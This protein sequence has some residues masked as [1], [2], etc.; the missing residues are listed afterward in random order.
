MYARISALATA[1]VSG[2]LTIQDALHSTVNSSIQVS[3]TVQPAVTPVLNVSTASLTLPTTVQG[4]AGAT[5]SFTANGSGLGSG[6]TLTLVAPTGSEISKDGSSFFNSI[7]LYPDASGNLS[8][9]TVYTRISASAT[10]SVS[11]YLTIQDALQSTLNKSIQVSGPLQPPGTVTVSGRVVNGYLGGG[12]D[13]V[14]LDFA[15]GGGSATTSGGGYYTQTL[16]TNGWSGVATPVYV[17]GSFS[18]SYRDYS[19]PSGN[20]TGQDYVWNPSVLSGGYPLDSG[21]A[22]KPGFRYRVDQIPQGN[23]ASE[24]SDSVQVA[25]QIL[26]GLWGLNASLASANVADVSTFTDNGYLDLTTVVNMSGGN[27]GADLGFFT[28]ANGYP[29][30]PAPGI[31]GTISGYTDQFAAE[32]LTY[33][34][35][36]TAGFYTMGV[37]S[38]ECFRV[39]PVEISSFL[40]TTLYVNAPSAL[41][42]LRIPGVPT[43]SSDGGFGPDFPNIPL[44]AQV[45]YASP[46]TAC[47]GSS[48][49]APPDNAAAL[50]GKIAL[51]DRGTCEFGWKALAAQEAGAI[52]VI[53][54]QNR[55]DL[56]I[57][58]GAGTYGGQVTIPTMMISQNDGATLEAHVADAGGVWVTVGHYPGEIL[59]QYD[60]YAGRGTAETTF[61][62]GV[63]QSGVYPFRLVWNNGGGAYGVEWFT[64][65]PDGTRILLND[66]SNPNA[67]KAYSGLATTLSTPTITWQAP[68]DITYGT[69][70]SPA[71]LNATATVSGATVQGTFAYSPSSGMVLSAGNGQTLSATFT[72]TDTAHYLPAKAS[73]S[74]NV[75]KATLTVAANNASRTYGSANPPFTANITGFVNGDT[76][77]VVSGA[78]NFAT[79]ATA[80][81]PVGNYAIV[82]AL[83]TLSAANYQFTSFINGTLAV[84]P[85]GLTVTANNASRAYGSANPAFTAN[86]TGFVN[87]DTAAVVSGAP[88]FTTPATA[89]S[90]VGN[91][92]IVPALGT[93]SAAN[94]QFTS[95]INGTLAVG[96]A[97][98]TVMANNASRAYGSANPAFTANITGFVNGDTFAVVSGAPS[99]TT[100]ATA[101]SPVGNYAIVPALGTLSVANY[102]F[103]SFINGT[104]AVGAAGLTVMANNASRAYGSAN[105]GFT[106]NITGFVNGDTFAVVSGAPSFTTPA[107]AG[108]P[109]GN[110]AIVPALGTLSV[111]NYQFTSFI[112]GTLA[113]GAAGLTVMANNASRAYGSANPAFTANI[114]GFVNGDTAAVVS[115]AP[116]FT[117][118]ATAGSPVGNYA[119]V[120]ALGTLSAANYQFTSFINGTLAV[121]PA[122]LTVMANNASRAYGS[123][124]PG[125]T[126]NI[127]GFVNG[128]T[129]AVVS[130]APSFTTPATAGSPVGNYA[131]VP[132][133]GTLSAANYQFTSF[134]NGTLAVGPAG[135][136]VMANNASR[137]YGSANPAFT[138]N[139]TGFVNGDTAAV[140]SGAPSLTTPATAGSPVGNYAIVPALGT[141]SAANYQFSSF[142]NG[143]LAVGP[144]ALTVTANNASRAYGSANPTFTANITGF[145]NGDTAAVVSG[146]PIFT[147]PATAGS[148]VGNYAI[149]PAL[150]TLSA[151][152]YQ[153]TSFINGTLAVGPAGLTVTANNASRAYGSANPAFTANITGFVNG[154]TAAVV[155]GAPS[156]TTPATAGSPVGNY[157]IVPALGTLSAANYQFTSFI[158][159]ALTVGQ[160][161]PIIAWTNPAPL[162]YGTSLS[163]NQLDATA[164]VPGSF[165][166]TPTNGTV[167]NA[168]TNTLSVVFIPSD[169]VDYSGA[170]DTVSLVVSPALLTVTAANASRAYGQTDP[171]FTG[172]ITG[173]TNGDNITATYSCSATTDSPAGTY[174]I[175]PS[176][177]DPNN[178]QTNYTVSL[179]N[180]TMT[181]GQTTPQISIQPTNQSVVLG[182]SASFS[183]S[184]TGSAPLLYQWQFDGANL[185]AATNTTLVLNAVAAT[186]AG[187]YDVVITNPYGSVTSAVATLTVLVP[188]S[189]TNPVLV[190]HSFSVS[191]P[192]AIRLMYTLEC[193]DS[194]TKPVWTAA[195]TLPGTG[196]SITLTDSA[197]TNASRFYRVRVK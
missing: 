54:V 34:E 26:A 132:A 29:D 10:A 113:V 84:G 99:F 58:Q 160:A 48:S 45:V 141:L 103:T 40:G 63:P 14:T 4:T 52:A 76:A 107:T 17:N 51:I 182:C 195:Q 31:P 13:G 79:P 43:L 128:D 189:I 56:P 98:L 194:L 134:I 179:V 83:G 38:D 71:Q 28:S 110:Y 130:G 104:L 35:F 156:F 47:T 96:A 32:F 162:T 105:P 20:V 59:G 155:S 68:S 46:N 94:Y 36:S 22:N 89:G 75:L 73:V 85:A 173:L 42:G 62:F 88:S 114:T 77:A 143:T 108:S 188:P 145:V 153:F 66:R 91:Y 184:A 106:A 186:N 171:V 159:G 118:P 137:A 187:G 161:T 90:P 30:S 121:G 87:G 149:V 117:T 151:A 129:F 39:T 148:P 192:T 142:I 3:G 19:S 131:I 152:N 116:S 92:A 125:F 157:A 86:I 64:V 12:V 82:P 166:Y 15:N 170:T 112:N 18:P 2:Y 65:Q 115:G 120:P 158:N 150:G 127:T 119:I 111:A 191:I 78:P 154:D 139:I 16:P 193:K 122:G 100:P 60:S 61:S 147:T 165:G 180:G 44:A 175:V 5:T 69:P 144:A 6:D 93:L 81:S 97:G 53:I 101:G 27:G 49:P 140:V 67:L 181:V 57:T 37:T 1:S 102:Q 185:T 164:S 23:N 183:V 190:G 177:V 135:L 197:A 174:P 80:G 70:L 74:I 172:T 167:L 21:D 72:P 169:M 123:A 109:V 24:L 133:L 9:S 126:A 176:L 7:L 50:A 95:F 146:A 138:A 33:V 168:G 178:R 196:G 136:T 8:T 55:T 11:G 41:S 25:E 163:S 124:N